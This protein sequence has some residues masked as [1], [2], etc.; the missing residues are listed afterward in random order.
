MTWECTCRRAGLNTSKRGAA[1]CFIL[2]LELWA[3]QRPQMRSRNDLRCL[4]GHE[5]GEQ[6]SQHAGST[7]TCAYNMSFMST[8]HL[9]TRRAMVD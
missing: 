5:S 7:R 3:R 1:R 4:W 2:L 9:P 6:S 8:M